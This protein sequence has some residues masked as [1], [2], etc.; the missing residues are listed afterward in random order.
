[1]EELDEIGSLPFLSP[2]QVHLRGPKNLV[3]GLSER[4]AQLVGGLPL[5]LL[6]ERVNHLLV[7]VVEQA[8][9]PVGHLREHRHVRVAHYWSVEISLGVLKHEN[10]VQ[11]LGL[12]VH[13]FRELVHLRRVELEEQAGGQLES[14][15][16]LEHLGEADPVHQADECRVE[17]RRI[18][19]LDNLYE[20]EEHLLV[21]VVFEKLIPVLFRNHSFQINRTNIWED[22]LDDDVV[23][24]VVDLDY[25]LHP[26]PLE[27]GACSDDGRVSEVELGDQLTEGLD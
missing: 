24:I 25:S 10:V 12:P 6:Q 3:E 17:E 19:H 26:Q 11:D 18:A 13:E 5:V 21:E 7:T 2:G 22:A 8:W 15:L 16:A 9:T 20:E 27:V 23:R 1:V 4:D 14:S